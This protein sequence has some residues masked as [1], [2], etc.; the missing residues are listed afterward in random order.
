M[1]PPRLKKSWLVILLLAGGLAYCWEPWDPDADCLMQT[2]QVSTSPDGRWTATSI[3]RGCGL[4]TTIPSEVVDL[5]LNDG[6]NTR[7]RVFDKELESHGP[8][9]TF[10]WRDSKHLIVRYVNLYTDDM[11][12]RKK[13]RDLSLEY[14]PMTKEEQARALS[15][16]GLLDN[17]P[18]R[19]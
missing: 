17:D 12:K 4:A 5:S 15:R 14:I 7:Y 6:D 3:D 19:Q 8:G 1:T 18:S 2:D 11:K 16:P 9:I 13:V 10:E